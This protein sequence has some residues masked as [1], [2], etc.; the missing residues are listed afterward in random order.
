MRS[1]TLTLTTSSRARRWLGRELGV[2]D[3]GV[4]ALGD[5]DVAQLDGLALAEVGGGVG[6]RPALQHAV[7]HLGAGGLGER[8]ELA[9]RVLGVV[10]G[11]L[12]PDGGEHDPLEPQLAVLDLGDVLELGGQP[13]DAAQRG[14]LLAVELVA[15]EGDVVVQHEAGVVEVACEVSSASASARPER[16]FLAVMFSLG[17]HRATPRGEPFLPRR[18]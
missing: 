6:V 13:G 12:A 4:G 10:G 1:M 14:A 17:S 11:A 18:R 9:H 15:V 2:A 8:G 16:M 7:E 5:D 3:D